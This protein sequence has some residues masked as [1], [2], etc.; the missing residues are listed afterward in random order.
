MTTAHHAPALSVTDVSKSHRQRGTVVR[1]VREVSFTVERGESVALVGANGAG[2]SSVLRLLAGLTRPDAGV[3]ELGG[4]RL[5]HQA[6][7]ALLDVGCLIDRPGLLGG[8][9][10]Q[11]N[12]EVIARRHGLGGE[13]VTTILDRC[14]LD[15]RAWSRTV[16]SYSLGMRQRLGLAVALLGQPGTLLLDEPSTGIDAAGTAW[17]RTVIGEQVASGGS[18]LIASH[19]LDEVERTCS[20][21]VILQ[22]GQVR[23]FG[24]LQPLRTATP[25]AH[26]LAVTGS[27]EVAAAALRRHGW[28]LQANADHLALDLTEAEA[29]RLSL[30]LA[31]EGIGITRL[32][33]TEGLLERLQ[34]KAS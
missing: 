13:P 31:G 2:K 29:G 15:R 22:A 30:D 10:G 33:P 19:Q 6:A 34:R 8:L 20:S 9:S 24:P 25:L 7:A 11:A 32:A 16:A 23:F 12:L 21:A 27:V 28:T 18:V 14:G 1:A 26:A 4:N 17:L 3:I 5:P